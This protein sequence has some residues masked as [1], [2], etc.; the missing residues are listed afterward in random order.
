MDE[1]QLRSIDLARSGKTFFLTG[2]GGT[3]KSFVIRKIVE[4]LNRDG[5]DVA[6]TAMT[7]C[8]AILLGKGAKTL[9][10]WAGV[11]LGKETVEQL[12]SKIRKSFK[13]K[14]NWLGFDTLIIDEISMMTP[15]LLDKL[16]LIGMKLRKNNKLFGGLQL[17]LV[18]DL[19]QLPPIY[20]EGYVG[21]QFVFE[22]STW[23]HIEDSVTLKTIH[24]QSDTVF[25]KILQEAREGNLSE[26]SIEI[27]KTRKTKEWKKL[28]IKPTLLFTRRADV[29]EINISQLQKCEGPDIVFKA[30]TT[31]TTGFF[32]GHTNPQAIEYAI[33]K[34]D[35][36]GSY[37]KE[38]TLRKG[39]QVMLLTNKYSESC[40]L[41][42]GSRGVV[43]RFCEGPQAY[44]MVKFKNGETIIVEPHSWA[45]EEIEGLHREQMPLRLAYAI[46][47]HKAQGCTLD[48]AL[49]D[50]GR[51]TFEAGQA[52]VALSRVRALDCLY[53]WDFDPEAFRVHPKVK[54]F[55]EMNQTSDQISPKSE[56][57][58]DFNLVSNEVPG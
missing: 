43:E 41:V 6:L 33:D 58:I 49:I 10:S 24:R 45:S 38:L 34:M 35:K 46:T 44:P 31:K 48:C 11:G 47:I 16:N 1:D 15:D 20:R 32:G 12:V 52:Y 29:E 23:K 54:G 27:I 13:A 21:P 26:E 50:I 55:L 7:G 36:G 14:K 28:E 5:K 42:N 56:S 57:C 9:H 3:G 25:I 39:A 18:G 53:I 19:Y 4:S 22:S 51:N 17:I 2:A 40:G 37:V 8:A 30:K